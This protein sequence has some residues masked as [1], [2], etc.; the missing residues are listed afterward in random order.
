MRQKQFLKGLI[1]SLGV[2]LA[3]V[4][5]LIF[6]PAPKTHEPEPHLDILL[7]EEVL[8]TPINKTPEITAEISPSPKSINKTTPTPELTANTIKQE[9]SSATPK[10]T[11]LQT[12]TPEPN[13]S[14]QEKPLKG[15]TIGIDPG[16][17]AHDN[18]ELEPVAPGSSKLKKKVSA[19]TYGR[20]TGTREHEVNLSVG[21]LLK[22]LLKEAGASVVMTRETADVNISNAERAKF[23]NKNNVDIAVRLHCNGSDDKQI[24]GAFV[25][26]PKT[27]PYKEDCLLCAKLILSSYGKHTGIGIERGVVSRSDQTGFNWCER[28]IINIEM[29]HMT[30]EEEDKKLSDTSFHKKMA[31]GIYYGILE[32]FDKKGLV[33]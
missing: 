12:Q 20:F 21:L 14:K 17:Q 11:P 26:I 19:G 5:V 7:P 9:E 3:I 1:V 13:D 6:K 2:I 18:D 22:G 29:G 10:A 31:T 8:L 16:H 33:R 4:A 15:I 27:N 25:L 30:N 32:Y 24:K 23:F 28:P